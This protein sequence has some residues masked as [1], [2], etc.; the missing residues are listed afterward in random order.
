M[1][2]YDL[3]VIG[4]GSGGLVAAT[5]GN[6]LGL[7]TILLE[8]S[9]IGGECTHSGCIPS[10]AI[11]QSA[12]QY[13]AMKQAARFGLPQIDVEPD[14]DFAAVME[15]VD[16]VVQSVYQ[17]ETP[18]VF[19]NM[20]IDVIVHPAGAQFLSPTQIR[21]GDDTLE[22]AHTIICTGSSPA[23]M[24]PEGHES[25]DLLH[26]ENFWELRRQP[27]SITF[28][29]GG[30]I[31]AE[32]GQSLRRFGSEVNIVD[33]NPRILK[34]VDEDVAQAMIA[35]FEDE[36]I[37]LFHQSEVLTC[38]KTNRG[39]L[40]LSL[41][42]PQGRVDLE[43]EAVFLAAGRVPNVQGMQ[44]EKAGVAPGS[45]SRSGCV[46]SSPGIWPTNSPRFAITAS[47]CANCWKNMP[48]PPMA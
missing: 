32:L 45:R 15:H 12:K 30:I 10:K 43:S 11:I 21:M 48:P 3:C 6:R 37:R 8:R 4:A 36:G 7:K 34:V 38:K 1:N 29:G 18:D 42:T 46:F 9:K 5:T 41:K 22:A 19:Q 44:L 14:F 35:I 26:N 24:A 31:S 23:R 13:H 47:A 17:N 27:Q 25:I 2:K 40:A 39:S 16:E 28:I 33:R 20:G